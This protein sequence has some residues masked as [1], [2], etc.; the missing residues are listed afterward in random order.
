MKSSDDKKKGGIQQKSHIN[1]SV[2]TQIKNNRFIIWK[3]GVI[4][5]IVKAGFESVFT[6]LPLNRE[7][8]KFSQ[9]LDSHQHFVYLSIFVVGT[10]RLSSQFVHFGA[11]FTERPHSSSHR[12]VDVHG[13][14][15]GWLLVQ[16]RLQHH[17]LVRTEA[18]LIHAV[19]YRYLLDAWRVGY[20]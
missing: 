15:F 19:H 12:P 6:I 2:D 20:L 3:V 18:H 4:M 11:Y 16:H 5:V 14:L 10:L 9:E 1:L 17:E 13:T 8:G 7:E